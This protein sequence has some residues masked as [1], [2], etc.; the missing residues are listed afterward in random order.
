MNTAPDEILVVSPDWELKRNGTRAVLLNRDPKTLSYIILNPF[1]TLTA[2]LFNGD[3]SVSDVAG[4]LI[5]LLDLSRPEAEALVQDTVAWTNRDKTLRLLPRREAGD[6]PIP[7][8]SPQEFL[9]RPTPLEHPNRLEVPLT[10]NI[11][12]THRCQTQCRYCYAERRGVAPADEL[13]VAA[14]SDLIDQA[15]GLGI[16]RV[17]LLGGDPMARP[18]ALEV[19]RH[20]VERGMW[21][22]VSTKCHI[23]RETAHRLAAMGLGERNVQFSM[24]APTP[25]MADALV[26][27]PGFYKRALESLENLLANGIPVRA[28]AVLTPSNARSAPALVRTWYGLGI[29][30]M[31]LIDYGR[32][33][34]HHSDDLFMDPADSAWVADQV[35]ELRRELP[36][37]DIV[38]GAQAR[39]AK[40]D[41]LE[42]PTE[43]Q[44]WETWARRARCSG[45][46][47][48]MSVAPDGLVFLCEQ[49][50]Q[51]PEHFVG[52]LRRQTLMDVWNSDRLFAYIYPDREQ[53]IGS[54]CRDCDRFDD[55]HRASGHCFRDALFAYGSRYMPSPRCPKAPAGAPRIY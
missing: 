16:S 25:D 44:R 55:C 46:A 6:R 10:L 20:L 45:G 53:L 50:P 34:Y 9:G 2:S 12:L 54:A 36:G 43:S 32:S 17:G 21:F 24:D 41:G 38:Y 4:V 42:S 37:L 11:T 47:S 23:D 51:I 22:F 26:G 18:D 30:E 8:Y 49:I 15:A 39:D 19:F 14:W 40:K 3:R 13:S 28:K 1:Q 5:F 7:A 31:Q 33:H 27:S 48:S 35:A 52:D 29:R